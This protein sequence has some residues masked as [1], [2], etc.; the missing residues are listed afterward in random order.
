MDYFRNKETIKRIFTALFIVA[1]IMIAVPIVAANGFTYLC[2]DDF[3]FEAGAKDMFIAYG[4]SFKGALVR[5]WEYYN[6]NQGTFFFNFVVHF[7]RAYSRW[8]LPG[9]HFYMICVSVMFVVSLFVIIRK[10]L[11]DKTAAIM[12]FALSLFVIFGMNGTHP[13]QELFF[14]YTGTMNFTLEFILSFFSCT[15]LLKYIRG[16]ETSQVKEALYLIVSSILA[17]F[18]SGGALNVVSA[19]CSWLLAI[20]ILYF[21]RTGKSGFKVKSIIPLCFALVGAIVNVIGPG[22]YIRSNAGI[23]EGHETFL[24]GLR[25]AFVTCA[26]EDKIL[27]TSL[28]F[29]ATLFLVLAICLFLKVR[30]VDGKVST[31][32][33][34]TVFVGTWLIRLFTMFPVSYGYHSDV[35][36]NQRTQASYEIVAKLMYILFVIFL[37][38][39]LHERLEGRNTN[40]SKYLPT[41]LVA[42]TLIISLAGYGK[43]K[44]EIKSS[45]SYEAFDD[46]RTGAMQESYTVRE[47]VLSSLRLAEKESDAIVYVPGFKK[48]VSAYGMGLSVDCEEFVNRSAA[49]LFDLHTVTV[50]YGE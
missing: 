14:W 43:I 47:Y 42:I 25:D 4:S 50:I 33:L 20:E 26:S 22:N 35:I 39:W 36:G 48:A 9:F 5:A 21:I 1:A 30:I 2:E 10:L 34:V 15:L 38:Q 3:S 44:S 31:P 28:S 45:I 24:D 17:F 32:V 12:I 40:I 13:S 46:F 7:V 29:I 27:F 16:T 6:S 11:R 19:S 49:G 8:D 37:G 18:A 23:V 41:A